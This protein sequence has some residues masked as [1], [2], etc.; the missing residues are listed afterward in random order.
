MALARKLVATLTMLAMLGSGW[1][2]AVIP[3]RAVQAASVELG[4]A[5][6][7]GMPP[8]PD[9]G[10]DAMRAPVCFLGC[11]VPPASIVASDFVPRLTGPSIV[12][13][14]LVVLNGRDIAPD[15]HPPK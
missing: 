13:P 1:A 14:T 10:T 7:Q 5:D 9:C 12:R 11:V 3:L 8:C 6:Q 4:G 15:P 2:I